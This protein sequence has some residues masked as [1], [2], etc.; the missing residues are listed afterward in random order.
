MAANPRGSDHGTKISGPWG[1]DPR[2]GIVAWDRGRFVH[3]MKP[4]AQIGL[5][6]IEAVA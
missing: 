5:D 1:E 3:K 6:K 4:V 2:G